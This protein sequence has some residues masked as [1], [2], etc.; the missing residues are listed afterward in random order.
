M[1]LLLVSVIAGATGSGTLEDALAIEQS[2]DVARA[3]D[4]M[5]RLVR[6]DPTWALVRIEA[7]RLQLKLGRDLDRAQM[8]LDAARALAPENARAHYLWGLLMEERGRRREA[9]RSFE[10]AVLY[11][12][13]YADARFRLAGHYFSE[14]NWAEAEVHY[15][16]LSGLGSDWSQARLQLAASLE[17]EGKLAEA[18]DELKRLLAEQPQS[19][20]FRRKLGEFYTRT[21]RPEM[22]EKLLGEPKKKMRELNKSFR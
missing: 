4:S 6:G 8:H 13:D 11:R 3:L 17:K 21:Q 2:G 19:A 12:P 22:A 20:L 5:E 1:W 18:E 9:I 15:R 16:A 7:G 10:I 14:G